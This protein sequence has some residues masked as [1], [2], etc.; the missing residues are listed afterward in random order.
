MTVVSVEEVIALIGRVLEAAP[1]AVTPIG[2]GILVAVA[3][4]IAS[5][6]IRF[7]QV[8]GVAHALVLRDCVTLEEAGLIRVS[9][10]DDHT[11]R[12]F[13]ELTPQGRDLVARAG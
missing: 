9:R 13:L 1:E 10:R 2:A 3:R 7:A 5:D 11:Q 12:L 4:D 8:L 6:S